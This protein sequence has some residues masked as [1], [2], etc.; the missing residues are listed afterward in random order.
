MK[1]YE[2]QIKSERDLVAE[3]GCRIIILSCQVERLVG[4]GGATGGMKSREY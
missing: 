3:L 2:G 1:E 4:G